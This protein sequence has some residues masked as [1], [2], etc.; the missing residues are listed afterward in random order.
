MDK[1]PEFKNIFDVGCNVLIELFT[2]EFEIGKH[3]SYPVEVHP[4][5]YIQLADTS[6]KGIPANNIKS[7]TRPSDRMMEAV[8]S[9]LT[10]K[11][12]EEVG[13]PG[14]LDD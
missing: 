14:V 3:V 10:P 13:F 9:T 1:H 12:E 7:V 2:G 8:L 4:F 5:W 6:A 11:E